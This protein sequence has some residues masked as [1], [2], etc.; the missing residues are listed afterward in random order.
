MANQDYH[1]LLMG[2]DTLASADYALAAGADADG[3]LFTYP[4]RSAPPTR[5]PRRTSPPSPPMAA[6]PMV[7]PSMPSPPL[8]FGQQPWSEAGTTDYDAVATAISD[9]TFDTAVGTISF[10]ENGDVSLPSWLIYQWNG[11]AYQIFTP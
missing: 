5:L 9:G 11:G 6:M 1:P 10:N 8:R 2:G 7:S 3:T 4:A